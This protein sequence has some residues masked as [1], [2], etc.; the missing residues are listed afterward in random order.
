MKLRILFILF[1]L[2]GP[3]VRAD[4]AFFYVTGSDGIYR[5]SVDTVTGKL[6]TLSMASAVKDPNFL[7]L[8]PGSKSLYATLDDSVAAVAVG[9]DGALKPIN[10]QPSGG[11]GPCHVSVDPAGRDV[12]V[13]NYDGGCIACFPLNPDG[14]LG[15]RTALITFTGSG[16]DPNRQKKPYA[17]SVYVDPGDKFVYAC[18]L[19]TDR[20]WILKFDAARGMLAPAD[21]PFAKVPPGNGAR[22]LAFS[23]DGRFVYVSNEM[24]HSVTAFSR[25][26][27]TGSLTRHQTVSALPPGI[28]AQGVTTA[29]IVCDPLGKW[30]YV[31]NRGCDTIAVFSIASNGGLA[32]TQSTSSVAQYPRNF[33]ID[34]SGHWLIVAG[35]KDNRLAVL[36]IDPASGRLEPTDQFVTV[37]NPTCVLFEPAK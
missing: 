16:P 31:S 11:A 21:P 2:F 36:K 37:S 30:L 29:E 14:S 22:H 13:A 6:V 1:T 33:A 19:G 20:V 8:S 28:S 10:E 26:A 15:T 17:H 4:Q 7:A 18:D 32:L 5:D 25:N 3:S 12:L 9:S 34:P 24:G 23:P 27:I 35:Q